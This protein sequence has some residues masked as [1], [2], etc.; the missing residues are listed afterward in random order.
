MVNLLLALLLPATL[1]AEVKTFTDFS[2]GLN[3]HISS[4]KLPENQSPDLQ[5]V[6]LDETGSLT[7]RKGYT[8]INATALGDGG[9]DDV[10]AV[11]GLE[12]SD[13]DEFCVAFSSIS[14]YSSTDGCETFTIFASTLTRN[15]DVNCD[16]YNDELYCVNNQYNMRFDGTNDRTF[17]ANPSDLDFIRVFRNRCF[18]A[19]NDANPSRLYWSDLGDCNTW[20]VA[21]E[22]VDIDINDGDVITGIGEPYLNMLPV[23][24][25]FSSYLLQFDNAFPSKRKVITVSRTTGAKNHRSI[26]VYNNRIY[27][28]SLGP[29]GGQAGIYSH[30]GI[31][32]REESRA[33]RNSMDIMDTFGAATG[34]K[35]VD[36]PGS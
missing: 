2:G 29:N 34:R 24:K 32:V 27:F 6:I 3:T 12:Q 19:G 25:K 16:A 20:T 5:N 7:R 23:F 9:D 4:I 21:T 26:A 28:D 22:F 8:K 36:T 33:L 31:R 17:S 18:G 35:T 13:G 1:L 30:D 15:N 10:N 11:Y 14:A